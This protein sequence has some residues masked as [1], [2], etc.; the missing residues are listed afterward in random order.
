MS[1]MDEEDEHQLAST[2]ICDID[3]VGKF[4]VQGSVN[5]LNVGNSAD[6]KDLGIRAYV[7]SRSR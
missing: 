3:S 6:D 7:H 1:S 4:G 2:A 5:L